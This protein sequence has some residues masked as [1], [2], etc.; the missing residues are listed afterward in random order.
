M[1]MGGLDEVG[2][3]H[4]VLVD[5]VGRIAVVGMNAAHLGRRQIDLVD[6]MDLEIVLYLRLV[7]QVQ[8]V[9]AGGKDVGVAQRLQ[10][11]DDGRAD[12]T[13]MAGNENGLVQVA[14]H[15]QFSTDTGTSWP[16]CFS[17]A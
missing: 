9:A 15:A 8:L 4:Q 10:T 7:E 11:A 2:L 14:R 13:A 1:G 12:H 6:A 17:R 16:C 3:D 5:E